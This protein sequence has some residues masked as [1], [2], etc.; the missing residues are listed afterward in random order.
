MKKI[1]AAILLVSY[2]F[3][4]SGA[5]VDLHYCMGKLTGWDFDY[6]SKSGCQNC[7]MKMKS[8]KG[9]CTNKQIQPKVD[10]EQQAACNNVYVNNHF[11]A[12]IPEY[13]SLDNLLLKSSTIVIPSSHA[14]PLVSPV[15]FYL[16]DCN[17][18]I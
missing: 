8:D 2:A 18:R 10:K 13:S 17:F 5:Y 14:P 15:P 11:S 16:L 4:S 1:F 3:A 6:T 9:C 7:G 12:I